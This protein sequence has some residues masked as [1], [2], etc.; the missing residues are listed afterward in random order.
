MQSVISSAFT[1]SVLS[2]DPTLLSTIPGHKP[3]RVAAFKSPFVQTAK[4]SRLLQPHS[5]R[6]NKG[7]GMKP[8]QSHLKWELVGTAAQINPDIKEEIFLK[9]IQ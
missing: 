7:E 1:P 3:K 4:A 9:I 5:I 2:V 8:A 6:G